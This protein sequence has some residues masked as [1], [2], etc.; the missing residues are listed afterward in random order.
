MTPA[1][2]QR[3]HSRQIVFFCQKLAMMF[4]SLIPVIVTVRVKLKEVNEMINNV[5][6]QL[7]IGA[8]VIGYVAVV[9]T[10]YG[11]QV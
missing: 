7:I 5:D 10:S 4:L 2:S 9:L 11:W 3:L 6:P 8:P 1:L